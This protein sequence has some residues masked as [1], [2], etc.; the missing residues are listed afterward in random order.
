[1]LQNE[2]RSG[3]PNEFFKLPCRIRLLRFEGVADKGSGA[4]FRQDSPEGCANL[5]QAQF[6]VQHEAKRKNVGHLPRV[7]RQF[8]VTGLVSLDI[9]H[10]VVQAIL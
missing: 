3:M 1:M 8:I 9:G 4:E 10:G 7:E 5:Q 6:T 2:K